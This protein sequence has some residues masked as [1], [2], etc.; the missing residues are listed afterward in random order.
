MVFRF[1]GARRLGAATLF[2]ILT[3]ATATTATTVSAGPVSA[4]PVSSAAA[5]GASSWQDATQMV[6]VTTADW[7]A[8]RGTLQRYQRASADA[9]WQA[10]GNAT[11]VTVGRN[12]A[13][14]GLGLHE[15]DTRTA[16]ADPVKREGDGRAPAGVFRIGTAFGYAAAARTALPYAAMDRDDWCVD[17]PASPLYNRIVDAKHVGDPAVAGST[18]PMRRDLHAG[19][20]RRYAL[21]FVIEHNAEARRDRGSCIFAHLWKAP[22]EATAGCTAMDAAAMAALVAWLDAARKPVFVLLP[23]AAYASVAQAWGLP[24]ADPGARTEGAA[25]PERDAAAARAAVDALMQRYAGD[26]PGA[27]LLVLRDGEPVLA[28]G[29][30]LAVLESGTAVTPSTH[31]R[32]ASITKQF[33]ATAILLLAHDGKLALADPLRKHLPSLPPELAAI[34]LH[35][36]LTHTSGLVDYE[37]LMAPGYRGQIHDA[38]VLRL[39]ERE[40][41]TYFPPGS[42]YRYS[43]SGYSLLSLV[44]ARA[45]GVDFPTF[46]RRRVF[47]P[48]GMAHTV[49]H[50]EGMDV[51]AARAYGYSARNGRWARTDQSSTSAVLGDGGIYAS[52]D[53]LARWDAA[54]SDD[55]LLPA[56]LRE[57]ALTAHTATDDANVAYGYGWRITGDTVWHSGETIGFRNVLV[58]WPK[59]RYTVVLL[60]NRDEPEPYALALEIAAAFG[61]ESGVRAGGAAEGPPSG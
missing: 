49:A 7:N 9:A 13:A 3:T 23:A 28:R 43:N 27:A 25:E 20:D 33:T 59:Q 46:L 12:G 31:F 26:G 18:E 56:P 11:D 53:D 8:P 34:T 15:A 21:G 10:V 52:I 22:G 19:G 37:D 36:V 47:A 17:V 50:R 42:A 55:R 61:L 57:R 39:L 38:D 16:A 29:Y 5:S 58:R 41:R 54:W 40:P 6:L 60:T 30:G 48:L 24:D 45:S 51:V 4:G 14:W 2:A 44:I 32:L 1:A 35:Q